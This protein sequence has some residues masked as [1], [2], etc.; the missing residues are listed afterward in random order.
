MARPKRIAQTNTSRQQKEATA[1]AAKQKASESK[2]TAKY[3]EIQKKI[4]AEKAALEA[5]LEEGYH[6][7]LVPA[8]D[9][10]ISEPK[11]IDPDKQ[12]DVIEKVSRAY[13]AAYPKLEGKYGAYLCH[14]A[15]GV[16]L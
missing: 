6:Y 16:E 9:A 3:A 10:L 12:E 5:K 2:A 13:I 8:L 7:A 11:L 15:D 14:S 4:A 1:A